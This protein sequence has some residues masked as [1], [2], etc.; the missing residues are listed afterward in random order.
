LNHDFGRVFSGKEFQIQRAR[1]TVLS[2]EHVLK[3]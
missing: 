3:Q 2:I 1:N